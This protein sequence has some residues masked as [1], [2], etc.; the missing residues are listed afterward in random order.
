VPFADGSV[1]FLNAI[2]RIQVLA[3]LC[4]RAGGEVVSAGDY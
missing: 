4:T 2:I 1:R 3:R